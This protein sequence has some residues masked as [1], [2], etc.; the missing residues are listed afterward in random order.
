[1]GRKKGNVIKFIEEKDLNPIQKANME[2]SLAWK[3]ASYNLIIDAW[4][5]KTRIRD[6]KLKDAIIWCG[7]KGAAIPRISKKDRDT[8]AYNLIKALEADPHKI[9]FDKQ[10]VESCVCGCAKKYYSWVSKVCH[11][12]NPQRNCFAF[13][14]TTRTHFKVSNYSDIDEW[15]AKS[16]SYCNDNGLDLSRM[17]REQAYF[18]DSCV[19]AFRG[20]KWNS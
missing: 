8:I 17:D 11:V 3:K 12:L 5:D 1:M 9:V 19:W 10:L 16:K 20:K 18:Y 4:N 6:S 13:D 15:L 2:M 7:K 14:S